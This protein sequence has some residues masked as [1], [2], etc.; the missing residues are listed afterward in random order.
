MSSSVSVKVIGL[1]FTTTNAEISQFFAD[2]IS[3]EVQAVNIQMDDTG[4]PNGT[5]FVQFSSEEDVA[6][7]CT[8]HKTSFGSSRWVEVYRTDQPRNSSSS[9]RIVSRAPHHSQQ[10][11]PLPPSTISVESQPQPSQYYWPMQAPAVQ[12]LRPSRVEEDDRCTNVF[13]ETENSA[14]IKVVGYPFATTVYDI[15]AFFDGFSLIRINMVSKREGE[16]SDR[17]FVELS[18]VSDALRA[19]SLHK[20]HMGKRY[21]EVYPAHPDSIGSIA[22]TCVDAALLIGYFIRLRGLPFSVTVTDVE[23]FFQPHELKPTAVFLIPDMQGEKPK[24]EAYVQFATD[25]E[26]KRALLTD[27]MTI[28]KRWIEVSRSSRN[29]YQRKTSP[30]FA[31]PLPPGGGDAVLS[32]QQQHPSTLRYAPY[33]K[34]SPL[35]HPRNPFLR[36]HQAVNHHHHTTTTQIVSDSTVPTMHQERS[37][38]S[39]HHHNISAAADSSDHNIT[40]TTVRL[41]GLPF[42]A[43]ELDVRTFLSGCDIPPNGISVISDASGRPS[44]K[45]LVHLRF[46]HDVDLALSKHRQMMGSRFIEVYRT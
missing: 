30:A 21:I 26:V 46:A 6:L 34:G 13:Q 2:I 11:F 41:V 35:V 14:V 19:L 17:A 9:S 28:G 38:S 42:S 10:Y 8:K 16:R 24:G 43:T 33:V 5:A 22:G 39:N 18:S 37:M 25:D 36:H 45:V 29:E 3:S 12:V 27:G 1:P 32:Q 4:H 20:Q 44:G 23:A 7:A 15:A 31:L 40:T